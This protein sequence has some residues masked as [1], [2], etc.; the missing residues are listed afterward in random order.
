MWYQETTL[1]TKSHSGVSTT[2][3]GPD[4]FAWV[5]GD[6]VS[7]SG[8]TE[9]RPRWRKGDPWGM[10]R[11]R[12]TEVSGGGGATETLKRPRDSSSVES[13]FAS[14]SNTSE[15]IIHSRRTTFSLFLGKCFSSFSLPH[16]FFGFQKGK[17]PFTAWDFS[18]MCASKLKPNFYVFAAAE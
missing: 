1:L 5:K 2:I 13:M 15:L 14:M 16:E 12:P 6:P 11:K 9:K 7:S 17:F 3:F 10:S 8:I 4:N 18:S